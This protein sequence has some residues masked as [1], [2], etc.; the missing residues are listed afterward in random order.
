MRGEKKHHTPQE[1]YEGR[2]FPGAVFFDPFRENRNN[3]NRPPL[4][5]VG[6]ALSFAICFCCFFSFSVSNSIEYG[7]LG[8]EMKRK[9]RMEIPVS[10][11]PPLPSFRASRVSVILCGP[12]C[13]SIWYDN[14]TMIGEA[15]VRLDHAAAELPSEEE[16]CGPDAAAGIG[17]ELT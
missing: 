15:L 7:R 1:E 12:D 10:N 5:G 8:E 17:F 4:E 9:T 11:E 6:A 3:P 13:M 16:I 2:T 14:P